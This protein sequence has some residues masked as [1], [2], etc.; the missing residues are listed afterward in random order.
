MIIA[1]DSPA[2]VQIT[3]DGRYEVRMYGYHVQTFDTKAEALAKMV[4]EANEEKRYA[5][6]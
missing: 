5:Y 2:H 4:R 1:K 3:D 6:K